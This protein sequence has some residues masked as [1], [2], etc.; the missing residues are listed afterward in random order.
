MKCV[1][2]VL[3]RLCGRTAALF[4]TNTGNDQNCDPWVILGWSLPLLE[5]KKNFTFPQ[6]SDLEPA[7]NILDLI[8]PE[9]NLT[10]DLRSRYITELSAENNGGK[11]PLWATQKLLLLPLKD[12]FTFRVASIKIAREGAFSRGNMVELLTAEVFCLMRCENRKESEM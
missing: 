10:M 9:G 7:L 3:Y 8:S 1:A 11:Q 12:P 5:L 6:D 4:R 2:A